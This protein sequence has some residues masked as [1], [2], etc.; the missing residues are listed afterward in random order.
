MPYNVLD[1]RG[2]RNADKRKPSKAMVRKLLE[3]QKIN[4][5]DSM[6][7][8]LEIIPTIKLMGEDARKQL[9]AK[10][11]GPAEVDMAIQGITD[12]YAKDLSASE[13]LDLIS[14]Y[15][16]P[17]G[18]K[19]LAIQENLNTSTVNL[20]FN[21]TT[22]IA[23]DLFTK[24]ITSGTQS[25]IGTDIEVIDLDSFLKNFKKGKGGPAGG[26]PSSGNSKLVDDLLRDPDIEEIT[27]DSPDD[28]DQK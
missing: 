18:Q 8:M 2:R 27:D 28:P 10:A 7:K 21:M 14:F 22:Q 13:V 6:V 23:L 1:G 25:V 11:I 17:T 15:K 4:I 24:I 12:I 20:I 16:S 5:G 9:M 26:L 19:V 3:L